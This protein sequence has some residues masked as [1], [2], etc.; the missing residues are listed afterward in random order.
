MNVYAS[1]ELGDTLPSDLHKALH[2][3][4]LVERKY[5]SVQIALDL[6]ST[7]STQRAQ[8]DTEGE[9][10]SFDADARWVACEISSTI[11]MR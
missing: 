5:G 7:D 10:A 11:G 1:D 8:R 3:V 4:A 9:R 2:H 6:P